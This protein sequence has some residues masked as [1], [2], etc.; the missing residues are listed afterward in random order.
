MNTGNT[1]KSALMGLVFPEVCILCGMPLTGFQHFICQEC[2]ETRFEQAAAAAD[3]RLNLPESVSGRLALWNFDKGGYLQDLLHN[4]KYK[5]LMGLGVDLGVALGTKMKLYFDEGMLSDGKTR[6]LPVPLHPR[7]KKQRGFNQAAYLAEGIKQA[8]GVDIL[9]DD[10]VTRVK[11]TKTQT[12][13]TLEKRR[14]N[15]QGAFKVEDV[16][17]VKARN[18]IIVDD[19]FTTGATCFE[20]ADTLHKAGAKSLYIVT[21]AQA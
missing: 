18:I 14:L 21:A 13:F 19:V 8:A 17:A 1:I 11:N 16:S 20:L 9:K 3:E 10:A 12:G 5:R 7:R 2:I 15:I 6:L 4:L